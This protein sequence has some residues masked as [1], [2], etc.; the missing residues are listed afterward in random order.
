MHSLFSSTDV[1]AYIP[2]LPVS[3][4]RTLIEFLKMLHDAKFPTFC[5]S[6]IASLLHY[7]IF[8]LFFKFLCTKV[9]YK[10]IVRHVFVE[11]F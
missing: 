11:L 1:M 5:S 2:I 7:T 4:I 8:L 6:N 9:R 10:Y 3:N